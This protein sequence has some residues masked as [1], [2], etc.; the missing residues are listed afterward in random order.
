MSEG[1]WEEQ[2][3]CAHRVRAEMLEP[4]STLWLSAFLKCS[5]YVLFEKQTIE[6][7][8][9]V[10]LTQTAFRPAWGSAPAGEVGVWTRGCI[11][12][13]V[14]NLENWTKG[15]QLGLRKDSPGANSRKYTTSVLSGTL[16]GRSSS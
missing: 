3:S 9:Q 7:A 13:P 15:L 14:P 12:A 11:A 8:G 16:E 4:T 10:G 1:R 2:G 6:N 5:H